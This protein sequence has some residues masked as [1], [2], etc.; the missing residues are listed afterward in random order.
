[1]K[2]KRTVGVDIIFLLKT[3][4]ALLGF[5]SSILPV[6]II[7]FDTKTQSPPLSLII[8]TIFFSLFFLV[9]FI[10]TFFILKL[11]ELSRKVSIFLDIITL[12]ILSVIFLPRM[13]SGEDFNVIET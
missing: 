4:F 1:M 13:F 7:Y 8:E 11:N 6:V 9:Y 10:N 5:S 2:K 3:P 12:I